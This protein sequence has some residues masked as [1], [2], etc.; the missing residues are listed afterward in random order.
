FLRRYRNALYCSFHTTAGYLEESISAK[1]RHRHERVSPFIRSFQNLFPPDANY[2]HDELD[3]R[4]ELTEAQRQVEPR[5][6]DSHLI[7]I[8]SGMKN[9][10]TYQNRPNTH[11]YFIDLDGVNGS[12][13]RCRRTTILGYN[14]EETVHKVRMAIPVSKH[15]VDS[16][17]LN[18]WRN[19]FFE[20]LNHLIQR[21]DIQN[22]RIRIAL[23]SDDEHA[24]LTVNEYETLL[25]K[26]DLAEILHNPIKFMAQKGKHA[27]TAPQ[28]I[29]GKTL[30]YAKYDLVHIFNKIM[31]KIGVSETVIEKY[32]SMLIRLPASHFL[33][34]KRQ[35]SLFVSE[36]RQNKSGKIVFGQ[37]QSPILVQWK[38]A[39]GETRYLDVT[40][41]RFQ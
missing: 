15:P 19:D 10:V 27:I 41:S 34:M 3:L 30:N 1:L 7:F 28:L 6:A 23:S 36:E 37:Y 14:R 9:C 2:Q 16:I 4:T 35:I 40:I 12:S 38:R 24:G 25:M 22:G 39:K 11:V 33:S 21:L 18:D 20:Q 32:L 29:M 17:N 13:S 26:H 31:D 5:N 8:S